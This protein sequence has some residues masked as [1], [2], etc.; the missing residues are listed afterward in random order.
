MHLSVADRHPRARDQPLHA[1]GG[2]LD[3]ADAVV[4]E[5][6]LAAAVELALDDLLDQLVFI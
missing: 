3:G 5:V 2:A 1:L 6:D 4:Q